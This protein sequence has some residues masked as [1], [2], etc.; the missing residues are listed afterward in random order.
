MYRLTGSDLQCCTISTSRASGRVPRWMSHGHSEAPQHKLAPYDS[1]H[2]L[3]GTKAPKAA[4]A[5]ASSHSGG[6]HAPSNT[7]TTT[8]QTSPHAQQL[9]LGPSLLYARSHHPCCHRLAV[10][11]AQNISVSQ[12]MV[13][14]LCAGRGAIGLPAA[15]H[16]SNQHIRQ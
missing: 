10:G 5:L 6:V 13:Q 14:W 1:S 4:A 8:S 3:L 15:A 11:T 12:T 9:P 2:S 7:C 16:S